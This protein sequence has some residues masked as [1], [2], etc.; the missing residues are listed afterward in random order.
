MAK[1]AIDDPLKYRSLHLRVRADVAEVL[2][3]LAE[4]DSMRTDRRIYV[5]E[6]HRASVRRYI[7]AR[8]EA[9]PE[10]KDVVYATLGRVTLS[11]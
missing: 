9:D 10:A 4:H 5:A 8:V 6:L 7:D 3:A 11:P 2:L 1:R